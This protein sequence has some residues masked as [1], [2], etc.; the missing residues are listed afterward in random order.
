MGRVV[1]AAGVGRAAVTDLGLVPLHLACMG[2]VEDLP[3]FNRLVEAAGSL[4]D[5]QVRGLGDAG[6]GCLKTS[7]E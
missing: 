4:Y 1:Y 6:S 3:Q 7:N 2:C 5:L